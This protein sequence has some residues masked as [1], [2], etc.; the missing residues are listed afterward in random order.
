MTRPSFRGR[1]LPAPKSILRLHNPAGRAPVHSAAVSHLVTGTAAAGT[2]RVLAADTTSIAEEARARHRSSPTAAAALGRSLTAALLLA[3]VLGKDERA[4]VTLRIQGGGPAGWIVA[5][6]SRDGS[7][8][9]YLRSPDADLPPRETDGKLDVGGLI[10]RDGDLA[11]TRLLENAEPYTGSVELVSGEVAEDVATYLL[12][13]EQIPSAV[14]LGVLVGNG[15]VQHA[16]GALVQ[17]MPGAADE[18]LERLEANVRAL[19]QITTA[20]R[21]GGLLGVVD[22]LTEGLDYRPHERAQ[23]LEFRCRCSERRALDALA[24]FG[25]EEREDMV[26]QGGQEVVCHWCGHR[27]QITSEQI[28]AA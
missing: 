27:Y 10:G 22:R 6:G 17:A 19:G 24:Y 12:R 2:L 13:S 5:E 16:G 18:T 11:V 21:H 20:M 1:P 23:S 4:R 9:G 7:V 8:R 26:R 25:P 15:G 3:Q 14:L 28:R